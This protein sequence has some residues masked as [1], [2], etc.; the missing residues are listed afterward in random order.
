MKRT[1]LTWW[2]IALICATF[3]SGCMDN[4]EQQEMTVENGETDSGIKE[5][6]ITL[7][8]LDT[9]PLGDEVFEE[10]VSEPVQ[11]A[12]P[13]IQLEY[14]PISTDMTD[15]SSDDDQYDMQI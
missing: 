9:V 15:L 1:C 4:D 8:F 5:D 10:W 2:I 7:S 14:L 13:H 3:L 11:D 6:T 12:F